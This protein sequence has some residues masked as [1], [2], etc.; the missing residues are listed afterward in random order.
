MEEV[1]LLA[2]KQSQIEEELAQARKQQTWWVWAT[3]GSE[4]IQAKILE[5]LQQE[6]DSILTSDERKFVSE[7]IL[8]R[9]LMVFNVIQIVFSIDQI[10]R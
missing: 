9:D 10:R 4:D 6:N 3:R 1:R 2:A 5:K 7:E 8:V